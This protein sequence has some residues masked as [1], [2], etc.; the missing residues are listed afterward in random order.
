M[1]FNI[2]KN[3]LMVTAAAAAS[4]LMAGNA[5]AHTDSLGFI[6]KDGS[7]AGLFDV[8]IFY[9][10][11]HANVAGPEGALD[12]K[13]AADDTLVGTE[14]FALFPGFENVADGVLPAGL[15]AGVNYFFPDGQGALTG[16][17]SGH[18]I[19]GF[20]YVS[21]ADLA[22]GS[23]TFGYNAGSSFT[24]DWMPS[25]PAINAGAFSIGANGGLIVVGAG[26][27][28]I[29]SSQG[30]FDISEFG[31][32]D[33]LTFDGGVLRILDTAPIN[34]TAAI[35]A[36]GGYIDTN[37]LNVQ[38]NGAMSGDGAVS[39][40][41]GGMLTLT[42][43]NTHGGFV[44][45]HAGLRVAN[46]AALGAAGAPLTLTHGVFAPTASMSLNRPL[47]LSAGHGSE[48][49]VAEDLTLTLNGAV[50]GGSCLYK[51][52][53]GTLDLRADAANAIGACVQNGL[54]AFNSTF[55]GNVWVDP[56]AVMSGAGAIVGDV[57]IGGVL[58]PGNSPGRMVV[59]GSVTQLPGSSFLV[60]IDGP[61]AGNGAG[62]HDDLTLT[63]AGAVFTAGGEL[64]PIL[65]GIS[66]PATNAYTPA[67]GDTFV[68]V[69]AE[70][71]VAGAFDTLTQPA[72]G[73]PANARID[74]LHT[75]N[76]VILAVTAANYGTLFG[77]E[78]L[79]N[80]RGAALALQGVRPAP[81]AGASAAGAFFDGLIGLNSSQ[82]AE[83]F[84][85]T[86]GGIHAAAM[87]SAHRASRLSRD[88]ALRR[89]QDGAPSRQVWGE[90]IG[91]D[92]RVGLDRAAYG[93]DY[94]AEGLMIGADAPLFENSVVGAA[95]AFIESDARGQ[96]RA[97][98]D[99]YQLT[100]YGR[101]SSG[102]YFVNAAAA[103]GANEYDITRQV[104]LA[105]GAQ[106]LSANV[107]GETLS[108]DIEGGRSFAL[109]QG[110]FDAIAGVA[111]EQVSRSAVQEIGAASV[112]L[113]FGGED[114]EA[115][116]VRLGGRYGRTFDAGGASV[117]PYVQAFAAHYA[118]GAAT[119]LRPMLHGAVFNAAS[120]SVDDTT[121]QAGLGLD[122]RLA[123]GLDLYAQ[124]RGEFGDNLSEHGLRLGARLGW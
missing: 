91:A 17:P 45:N 52:G 7:A 51:R 33:E 20:Q 105:S 59:A 24:I 116:L 63:G 117:R 58:S 44:V 30:H 80:A 118:E 18:F 122:A 64:A 89:L 97:G 92:G 95:F 16:D 49:N 101:W 108:F 85:Q 61:T 22:P 4:C 111:V 65:R 1:T 25:N 21:F 112:A 77:Q 37:Q 121:A 29:D 107:H 103:Y 8:D 10:T 46:D 70:G 78:G 68:I 75:A 123:N 98:V 43:A 115:A 73:L 124:Y 113:S 60:D 13:F 36:G 114:S 9:G 38:M 15:V 72:D 82:L 84:Q 106:A 48:I 99:T 11:W 55:T 71:G 76:T 40:V 3:A 27:K 69:T 109:G 19:Y 79:A 81:L 119:T 23:Y 35:G 53:L 50:S 5:L 120:P 93:Y 56:G 110:Q 74:V 31:A 96:G 39:I 62:H 88:A 34:N 42:G 14:T 86:A 2:Q 66:A 83:T 6:I 26:Q 47:I 104:N 57:E 87:A 102:A 90:A 41:G 94:Q 32:D 12:L 67:I 54:M 28:V 100:L